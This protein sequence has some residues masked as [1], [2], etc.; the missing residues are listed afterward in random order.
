MGERPGNNPQQGLCQGNDAALACWIMISSLMMSVYC[1]EGHVST[2]TSPITGQT[3]E[4]MGEIYVNDMDLLTI[5]DGEHDKN[6]I[7]QR[8]QANLTK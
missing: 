6:R 1:R 7:L 2:L 4:F 3:I 5:V 8:T